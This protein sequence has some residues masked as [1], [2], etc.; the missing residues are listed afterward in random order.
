MASSA[1]FFITLCDPSCP[2]GAR[3]PPFPSS[4]SQLCF[5]PALCQSYIPRDPIPLFFSPHPQ[6][7]APPVTTVCRPPSGRRWKFFFPSISS[8]CRLPDKYLGRPAATLAE[9]FQFF[10]PLETA[11]IKTIVEPYIYIYIYIFAF[12]RGFVPDAF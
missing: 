4:F 11:P 6:L 3:R 5:D 9:R 10:T 12:R 2:T 7:A 1:V 8:S